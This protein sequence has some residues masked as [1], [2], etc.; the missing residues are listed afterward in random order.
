MTRRYL[1]TRCNELKERVQ[2][3]CFIFPL[4]MTETTHSYSLH[5]QEDGSLEGPVPHCQVGGQL[6]PE[7][8]AL[9]VAHQDTEAQRLVVLL[10]QRVLQPQVEPRLQPAVLRHPQLEQETFSVKRWGN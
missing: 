1:E 9:A 4:N 6:H 5:L 2:T 3:V 8:V 7:G 10:H